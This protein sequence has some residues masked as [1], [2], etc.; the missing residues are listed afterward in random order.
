MMLVTKAEYPTML[1]PLAASDVDALCKSA[2]TFAWDGQ[3]GVLVSG[4]AVPARK[5]WAEVHEHV[6]CCLDDAD[7]G[8]GVWQRTLQFVFK[9][10]EDVVAHI[11]QRLLNETF[12]MAN[13]GPWGKLQICAFLAQ[14]ASYP[15]IAWRTGHPVDVIHAIHND[16]E[17]GRFI[18]YLEHVPTDAWKKDFGAVEEAYFQFRQE[19]YTD[20][21]PEPEIWQ[22]P[23]AM[24]LPEYAEEG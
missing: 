14:G 1:P 18:T 11:M 7:L 15:N 17:L 6:R 21:E 2:R 20:F 22:P 10:R 12:L 23:P 9:H 16:E 8:H 4:G 24:D 5:R 19:T 13:P 3:V